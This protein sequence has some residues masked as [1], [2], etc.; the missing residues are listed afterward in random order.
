M[1]AS[2]LSRAL[3]VVAAVVLA[4][5]RPAA[6]QSVART[7]ARPALAAADAPRA[8]VTYRFVGPRDDSLPATVTVADSAGALVARY[9][10]PGD[11]RAR[12][13]AVEVLDTDL[14]LQGEA[15]A[16]LLT[17]V[18]VGQNGVATP[19]AVT[20]RWAL[21]ARAGALHARGRR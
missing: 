10:L 14:V 13:L 5:A 19:G 18:L 1:S 21:G 3:T 20:G 9:W 7:Q 16:G 6:A 15:P 12:A 11:G 8:L 2:S 4:G 17:L